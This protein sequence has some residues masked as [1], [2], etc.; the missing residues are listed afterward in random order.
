MTYKTTLL[1]GAVIFGLLTWIVY[2]FSK[3]AFNKIKPGKEKTMRYIAVIPTLVLTPVIL[4]ATFIG[5]VIYLE[6]EPYS[7]SPTTTSISHKIYMIE[8]NLLIGKSK[9]EVI[10]LLGSDFRRYDENTIVYD[11]DEL[12][13]FFI[14]DPH[15][16]KVNFWS[17]KAVKVESNKIHLQE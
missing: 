17:G 13:Y 14:N 12:P 3:W 11:M 10:E 1:I 2:S 6:S 9:A 15:I 16:L 7:T 5:G 8:D 4:G